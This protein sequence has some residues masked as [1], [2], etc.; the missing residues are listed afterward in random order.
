[1]CM[2]YSSSLSASCSAL[3]HIPK[4]CS[5]KNDMLGQCSINLYHFA[6]MQRKPPYLKLLCKRWGDR[7]NLLSTREKKASVLTP[8]LLTLPPITLPIA[9]AV[10]SAL[11]GC[12]ENLEGEREMRSRQIDFLPL[13]SPLDLYWLL[14]SLRD[15]S[16]YLCAVYWSHANIMK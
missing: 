3:N 5:C 13:P 1:M 8:D 10:A 11:A 9:I 6:H 15:K 14:D 7:R 2:H 16:K 4:R 12:L